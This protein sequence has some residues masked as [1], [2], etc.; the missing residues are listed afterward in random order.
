VDY[1][2]GHS[3]LFASPRRTL[4][5]HGARSV[6]GG[7]LDTLA[8]RVP[9]LAAGAVAFDGAAHLIVPERAVWSGPLS[10]GAAGP[11]VPRAWKVRH[12]PEPEDY[13]KAVRIALERIHAGRLTKVVLARALELTGPADVREL[14]PPLLGQGHCFAVPLPGRTLIGA[15]PE[16][17]VA[18]SGRGVVSNPL[19]G[20]APRSTDPVED[21]SRAQDLLGSA[22]DLHEHQITVDAVRDAL[23]PYCVSL[24]WLP[25]PTL[26]ATETMWHLSS[27][28]V[29]RLRADTP[30]LE[31]AAALHPTPAVCGSPP[32]AARGV[33]GEVEPF[34]RGAY[35]GIVGWTDESGD[36]EW[37][38]TIRCAEVA[39]DT[40]R[41]FAGAG[42]VAGSTPQGEL[43]ETSAKFR[44][45]LR[46]MGVDADVA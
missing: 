23:D 16:L 28:V 32:S 40:V 33:I 35:S 25:K 22:K 38:V 34:E 42:V 24:R 19:A 10:R 20:S 14:L 8:G 39:G 12:L 45:M 30:S 17:L 18:K 6:I 43:A 44:T 46:A 31:L 1:V 27:T 9:R 21:L 29:G 3:L 13:L 11:S 36:G 41:L 15:S 2:P 4:L 7:D 5:A 26:V 37:A